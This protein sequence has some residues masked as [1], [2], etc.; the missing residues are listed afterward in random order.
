[1][2]DVRERYCVPKQRRSGEGRPGA[3]LE[4]CFQ[5]QL[6]AV[7][8]YTYRSLMT[9]GISRELSDVFDRIAIDEMEHFR[10]LGSLIASLGGDPVIRTSVQTESLEMEA[11]DSRTQA[12]VLT[13]VINLAVM[14]ERE[15]ILR[16]RTAMR[17]TDDRIV[18][19]FLSQLIT[20]EERHVSTLVR[21]L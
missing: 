13:E 21:L 6:C 15:E 5:A 12:L 16:Y 9:E 4:G 11:V 20:D 18:R 19:G 8:A 1:M 3:F 10:L 17:C 14:E 7:A 2:E